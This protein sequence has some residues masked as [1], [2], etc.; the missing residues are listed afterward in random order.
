MYTVRFRTGYGRG[1]GLDVPGAGVQASRRIP[2][3]GHQE[4]KLSRD[5]L[6]LIIML[7]VSEKFI[8]FH[9]LV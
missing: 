7:A 2:R 8:C 1:C 6:C 9:I 4:L 3:R 5:L